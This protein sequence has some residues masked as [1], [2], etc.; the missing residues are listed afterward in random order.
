LKRYFEEKRTIEQ[1]SEDLGHP[2]GVPVLQG[3]FASFPLLQH[4][5]ANNP[6]AKNTFD[7]VMTT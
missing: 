3:H 1:L 5:S 6:D 2:T 7:K 4:W